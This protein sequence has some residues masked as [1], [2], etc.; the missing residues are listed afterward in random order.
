MSMATSW[1]V[2]LVGL[3]GRIVQVEADIA[4][5]L[6]RTVLV[7]LPD[8]ALYQARDRCKAA[9]ANS[10]LGWP[11]SLL[12]INLG[13]A[14]LPK[15]GSHYDL[16]IASAVL[17][18]ADAFKADELHDTVLL[19]ELGLDG[20]VRS[21]RGILPAMLTAAQQGFRRAIVPRRQSGEAQLVD[22]IEVFGVSSLRQLIA[23]FRHEQ[24][25]DDDAVAEGCATTGSARDGS[26]DP[27]RPDGLTR[28]DLADVAGQAEAKWALEV[29]AAGRHHLM[30]YGPPGVGKTML[31]ERLPS[32]L[33]DLDL[34][35]ALEVSAIHSM[36]GVDLDEGLIRRPP[37]ANP[38]HSASMPAV[39]GGGPRMA[40][41]GAISRAHRGVLFLDE[42]PEFSSDVLEGLRQPL[43]S[44][45][46]FLHRSQFHT[47]YPARFQLIMAA[48]PCPCGKAA[49]PGADCRCPPMAIRRY[50]QRISDP[51]RDR[52]DIS[53]SFRPPR[54]SRI[55]AGI[56]G[57]ET[58]AQVADRV[59]A[60]R[61]RQARRLAGTEWRYNGEVAGPYLRR[62]LPLPDGLDAVD[63]AL[64]RHL[65]SPRG[66]DKVLRVAWT[67]ADLAGVDRPRAEDVGVAL[68]MRRGEP[69]PAWRAVG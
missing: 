51:I 64:D 68:A 38:H 61:D 57:A 46:V 21:V 44:G 56:S 52:I 28:I 54:R 41:P 48:N 9:A 37:Y 43:E 4:G 16:A 65:I 35:E 7:G 26:A 39:I 62:R 30:F 67:V 25:P 12:T 36:A 18:A 66:V 69:S 50:A 19:G 31:A 49:T 55:E 33:P 10:G 5:G 40:R 20:R 27:D 42:A 34:T 3:D 11:Q 32:L 45:E 13:P 24:V 29:A 2:A 22:G 53:Q 17:A 60:A 63:A 6:P 8:A 23:F 58:S 14:T 15:T 1:S 47:R 59:L